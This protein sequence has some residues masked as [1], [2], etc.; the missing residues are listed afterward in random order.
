MLSQGSARGADS[1]INFTVSCASLLDHIIFGK[2]VLQAVLVSHL[3][4]GY[5]VIIIIM[6]GQSL[7]CQVGS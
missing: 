7:L 6:D 4:H 1:D 5:M 2:P 3:L